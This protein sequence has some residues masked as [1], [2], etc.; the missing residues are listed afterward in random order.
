MSKED[1]TMASKL[2]FS[3]KSPSE[4]KKAEAISPVETMK[5]FQ[6]A[7][8]GC[9]GNPY[10]VWHA[11]GKSTKA[12]IDQKKLGISKVYIS[13][14]PRGRYNWKEVTDPKHVTMI[15]GAT[16][17]LFNT[18]KGLEWFVGEYNKAKS[19]YFGVNV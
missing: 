5:T 12:Y 6:N 1:K 18:K 17:K 3:R 11:K 10:I 7:N 8:V 16:M 13:T 2:N 9:D 4:I 19:Q 14:A 15:Y